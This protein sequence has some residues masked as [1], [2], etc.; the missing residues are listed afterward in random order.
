MTTADNKPADIWASI[1]NFKMLACVFMGLASGF[2]LYVLTQLVPAW[3]RTEGIDLVSIGL[4]SL[5]LL[6]FNW[7]FLWAPLMDQY[8]PPLLGRRTGWMLIT[9]IA[10]LVSISALGWFQ[11]QDSVTLIASV[12]VIVAFFSAS[13]DI[14]IDA[15]RRELLS[16][17]ELG[18]GNSIHVQAYRIAGLVPV[19]LGFT[20]ADH[21]EWGL[22]FLVIGS[23]MFVGISA[24]F[25]FKEAQF[26][27]KPRSLRQAVVEPFTEFIGRNHWGGT[28]S[29][30]LLM[31]LYKLGD[32]M[33][34][35]LQTPFFIDLGYSLSAI[36]QV[37]KIAGTTGAIVG[38]LLGGVSMLKLGINRA[39]WIFGVVQVV[40]IFGFALLSEIGVNDRAL[41]AVMFAEYVG[42]GLGTAALVAF[43]ARSTARE[44]AATQLALL[45]AISA[46]PRTFASASSGVII[47]AIGYTSF[48]YVCMALAVPGLLLLI[49]VAPWSKAI[50]SGGAA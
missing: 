30:I 26:V 46:L 20:L 9:Q 47:E 41:A 15:Y 29:I 38:G 36:G 22:V 21:F 3:L 50:G 6:P 5:L 45:T 28:A 48:F 24:S 31:F 14:V 34:V 11:P 44:F 32:N 49:K 7:K 23:F 4:F 37:A 39:L 42:V 16:D 2:P 17:N 40:T 19:T 35:A 18:L 13:Q 12:C 25:F 8:L 33:A 43:I 10:L 27:S 1:F